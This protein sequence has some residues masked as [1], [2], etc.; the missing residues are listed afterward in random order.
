MQSHDLP[1][2]NQAYG[3]G[4]QAG[5]GD[6]LPGFLAGKLGP[7]TAEAAPDSYA[8][9]QARLAAERRRRG[10][11][12]WATGALLIGGLLM[13][14][15]WHGKGLATA[16]PPIAIRATAPGLPPAASNAAGHTEAE[17]AK[18]G[19]MDHAI[20]RS[21]EAP[22]ASKARPSADSL[23]PAE[24]NP[25]IAANGNALPKPTG[26]SRRSA[27]LLP[28]LGGQA[29][30]PATAASRKPRSGLAARMA[31]S[32]AA[33]TQSSEAYAAKEVAVM[34]AAVPSVKPYRQPSSSGSASATTPENVSADE[35][36]PASVPAIARQSPASE[37]MP[38]RAAPDAEAYPASAALGSS[39]MPSSTSI[40]THAQAAPAL[41]RMEAP[42]STADASPALVGASA[43]PDADL[44]SRAN[45]PRDSSHPATSAPEPVLA[46]QPL[47][48][49]EPASDTGLAA[50]ATVTPVAAARQPS[51][52]QVAFG[53]GA[54]VFNRQL[55]IPNA[56]RTAFE[57]TGLHSGL[58]LGI[59]GLVRH[60]VAGGL[61][62]EL[63]LGLLHGQATLS[64]R[65][66]SLDGGLS[67]QATANGFA[68]TPVAPSKTIDSRLAYTLASLQAGIAWQPYSR[69]SASIKGGVQKTVLQQAAY[70]GTPL[71]AFTF[72]VVAALMGKLG[73]P[74]WAGAE[75]SYFG[76]G[77]AQSNSAALFV[78]EYR[79]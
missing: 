17:I 16:P 71:P 77:T 31:A 40:G 62:A 38:L 46:S 67:Y 68:G 6:D 4:G 60:R 49:N 3:Q 61:F 53:G 11:W 23:L 33:A 18:D 28:T 9:I 35:A 20:T 74:I 70:A 58:A 34:P 69:W 48:A 78:F 8:N 73:G 26:L 32:V 63:G 36:I 29:I 45:V 10:F 47:P 30:S 19:Q 50:P 14:L 13:G 55:L 56:A 5:R 1:E 15:L 54:G 22:T 76:S 66:Y 57:P 24:R 25:A 41:A 12:L 51:A 72:P 79:H 42:L 27:H 2:H 52:W 7:I 64:Q 65:Q 44:K 39:T 37:A 43:K 59:K 75:L 21:S